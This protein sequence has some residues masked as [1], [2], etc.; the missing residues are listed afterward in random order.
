MS[1]KLNVKIVGNFCPVVNLISSKNILEH[2]DL[3]NSLRFSQSVENYNGPRKSISKVS[4]VVIQGKGGPGKRPGRGLQE[5]NVRQSQN[6][7]RDY[8]S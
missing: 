5:T 2:N 3:V 6:T 8:H 7:S 1:I 4:R